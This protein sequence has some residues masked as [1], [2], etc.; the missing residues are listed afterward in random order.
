QTNNVDLVIPTNNK[1]RKALSMVYF[2][3]TRE[4]LKQ[5]GIV[6]SLTFEDFESEF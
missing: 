4:V 3:L 1:G 5:K 6:S 2:L